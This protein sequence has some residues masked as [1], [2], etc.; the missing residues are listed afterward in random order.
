MTEDDPFQ[1]LLV[2]DDPADAGLV[3]AALAAGRFY[4][5]VDHARDGRQALER[6][7]QA[8]ERGC[9]PDL[10]LLDINMPRMNGHEVLAAI[11]ANPALGKLPVV[12]LTTSEVERDVQAAYRAGA[13]GF[14]TKPIDVDAFFTAIRGIEDYWFGVVRR[15]KTSGPG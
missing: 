5:A 10:V 11:K 9:L 8:V 7:E 6:L 15:P 2:E 13:A 1:V 12:M 14:V 4:C 3:K